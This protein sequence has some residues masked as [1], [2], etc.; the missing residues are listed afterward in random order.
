MTL[1]DSATM[2]ARTLASS[3]VLTFSLAE[4]ALLGGCDADEKADAPPAVGEPKR[5]PPTRE[6]QPPPK[7]M[8]APEPTGHDNPPSPKLGEPEVDT[9]TAAEPEEVDPF[10]FPSNQLKTKGKLTMLQANGTCV[11]VRDNTCKPGKHCNP[12]KPKTVK[13]PSGLRLPTASNDG[14]VYTRGDQ[15]CWERESDQRSRRVVCPE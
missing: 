6:A 9:K 12:P 14:E 11:S 13:C 15:T 5:K 4:M 3:V 1:L 7:A 10:P 2:R 8:P